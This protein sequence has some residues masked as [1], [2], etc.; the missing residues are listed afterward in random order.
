MS[1]YTDAVERGLVGMKGVSS[2][3]CPGCE[4]CAERHDM[5]PEEHRKAW[6]NGLDG[7]DESFSWRPCGICRTSLGGNRHLWHWISGGDEHGK[8]GTIEHETDMC[9]DCVLFL[10]NGGTMK[11]DPEIDALYAALK[12]A[13]K[14]HA[15]LLRTGTDWE[16]RTAYLACLHAEK[17]FHAA[18]D[19]AA[20]REHVRVLEYEIEIAERR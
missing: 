9:T 8:G 10:A 4:S 2:G 12:E 5:T 17:A 20:D 15:A 19:T 16:L 3:E 6:R 13:E 1:D 14:R 18:Y 11:T 7:D